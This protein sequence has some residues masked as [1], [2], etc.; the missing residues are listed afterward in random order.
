MKIAYMHYHL[1]PGGVTTVLKQQIEAVSDRCDVLVLA[2]SLPDS[3]FPCDVVHI[4]DLGYDIYRQNPS[5]P[6]HVADAVMETIYSK[7]KDG[8][9]ILHIHNPTLKKNKNFLK[10]LN[11]LKN[12]GIRLF[13]QIH[14]FAEDGRPLSYFSD[15]EYIH[16]CHY[17]TINSRDYDILLKAGLKKE[18]VH[19]IFNAVK[20]FLSGQSLK[21]KPDASTDDVPIQHVLYPVRA[22]RRKNIGEAILLSLFFKNNTPLVITLPPNSPSDIKRYEAWKKFVNR[23][24]LNVVFEAGLTHEFFDLVLSADFLITTS[25]SEGFGFSFLEPWAARKMLWGRK[26]PDICQDFEN[27]SIRLNHLYTKLEIPM[28]WIDKQRFV[29]TWMAGI[30]NVRDA[31]GMSIDETSV[32]TAYK[33]IIAAKTIDYGLLNESFQQKIISALLSGT[34]NRNR[35]LHLNP[36]L[37]RPGELSNKDNLIQENMR[38]TLHNYNLIKY[39]ERLMD[40]Y[41]KVIQRKVRQKINKQKLLAEFVMPDNFSL[42]KWCNDA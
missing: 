19:K 33:N 22:I 6:E 24:H 23:H 42:L 5:P 35:L 38:A 2:G 41:S 27:N 31:F 28:D 21:A 1:K 10:I 16:D 15:Q 20:P 25:I 39:T 7:W 3:D 17:G 18:G 14:D 13:L 8:C 4:P 40:I 30:Q 36:C 34:A 37:L 26:L 11:A 12:K 32:K 9:D 29:D